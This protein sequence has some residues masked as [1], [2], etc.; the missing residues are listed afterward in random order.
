MGRFTSLRRAMGGF[1]PPLPELPAIRDEGM[2]EDLRHVEILGRLIL[3]QLSRLETKMDV[4]TKDILDAVTAQKG[5]IASLSALLGGIKA[6]LNAALAGQITPAGQAALNDILSE[7]QGNSRAINDAIA[8]NDDDPTTIASDGTGGAPEP[9]KTATST[10]LS[11]SKA[12]ANVGESV[13]LSA[14]VSSSTPNLNAITGSVTFATDGGAIGVA[15][16]DS[17]GVAAFATSVPAGDHSI[18]ATY[19]GDANFAASTSEAITQSA[20]PVTPPAPEPAPAQSGS[21]DT[22][23]T[24]APATP[25]VADAAAT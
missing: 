22:G 24:A 7:I 20:L 5:Q 19:G 15:S 16:L 8:T 10:T 11:T 25:G 2:V 13:T 12:V 23:T 4:T 6:R 3:R 17:T 14:G 18:T 1:M 9:A 21:T